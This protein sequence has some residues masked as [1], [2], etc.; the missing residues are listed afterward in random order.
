MIG[1][2]RFT[3][4]RLDGPVALA[5]VTGEIDYHSSP[6][7]RSEAQALAE[8]GHPHL[9]LDVSGVTF[10]DSSGLSVLI[11]LWHHTRAAGGSLFLCA[12]PEPLMRLVRMTGLAGLLPTAPDAADCLAGHPALAQG[13]G[14]GAGSGG[15]G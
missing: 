10:C 5:A 8:G 9:V 15:R 4:E 3:V 13:G 1:D 6:R 14:E 7:L 11:G 2:L 12:V